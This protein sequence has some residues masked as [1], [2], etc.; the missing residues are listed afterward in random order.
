MDTIYDWLSLAIFAGLIVLFLQRSTS[1]ACGKGRVAALLSWRRRRLRG[2]QLLRQQGPGHRRDPAARR[3]RRLHRLFPEAVPADRRAPRAA[4]G[5]SAS[6]DEAPTRRLARN[7]PISDRV[8]ASSVA[9]GR[10]VVAVDRGNA[11]QDGVGDDAAQDSARRRRASAASSSS[12]CDRRR[13]S[14]KR[15]ARSCPSLVAV[16]DVGR[17]EWLE[18]SVDM[19]AA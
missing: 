3:D 5:L 8:N 15:Y 9:R 10:C 2:R 13:G 4:R 1:D 7:E 14:S 12:G 19:R 17:S 18:P 11:H 6:G 16:S